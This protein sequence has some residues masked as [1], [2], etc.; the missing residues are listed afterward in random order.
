MT[1]EPSFELRA[2]I[3]WELTVL[4][5]LHDLVE[6]DFCRFQTEEEVGQRCHQ[7]SHGT[8]EIGIGEHAVTKAR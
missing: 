4:V 1:M 8:D 3:G 5:N 6:H 7:R 2:R